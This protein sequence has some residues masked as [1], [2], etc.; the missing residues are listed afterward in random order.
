[1]FFSHS[2]NFLYYIKAFGKEKSYLSVRFVFLSY[3]CLAILSG[4][5]LEF[6]FKVEVVIFKVNNNILN[7]FGWAG[8]YQRKLCNSQM[9]AFILFKKTSNRT[10][11]CLF[12]MGLKDIS[13]F[14]ANNCGKSVF[15]TDQYLI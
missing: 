2:N 10:G 5:F 9:T 8:N 15:Y 1:M 12:F 11:Q 13:Q 14:I 7:F 3:K 4:L 6:P